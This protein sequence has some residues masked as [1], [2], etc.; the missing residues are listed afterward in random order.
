MAVAPGG[1]D[2]LAAP[3]PSGRT[4]NRKC[5]GLTETG[6]RRASTL[7]G[8]ARGHLFQWPHPMRYGGGYMACATRLGSQ[9]PPENAR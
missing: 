2:L 9:A 7:G 5:S 1:V 6:A 8:W 4:R 3:E